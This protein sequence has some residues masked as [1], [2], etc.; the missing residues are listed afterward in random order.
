MNAELQEGVVGVFSLELSVIE[1]RAP[2]ALVDSKGER[3]ADRRDWTCTQNGL[4]SG[5]FLGTPVSM[6]TCTF[7]RPL[8]CRMSSGLQCHEEAG[9]GGPERSKGSQE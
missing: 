4:P 6:R 3:A 8:P 2:K 1:S 5:H 7:P 9:G